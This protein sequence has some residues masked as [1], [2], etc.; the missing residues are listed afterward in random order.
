MARRSLLKVGAGAGALTVAGLA[1]GA[2]LAAAA[3][4]VR[5]A[6]TWAFA[7]VVPGRGPRPSVVV[8]CKR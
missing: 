8:V 2:P 6:G 4:S 7:P 1:T 3:V 5:T